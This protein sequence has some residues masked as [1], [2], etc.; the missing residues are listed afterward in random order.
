MSALLVAD[1]RGDQ[2]LK[3]LFKPAASVA[4]IILAF[5][6]GAL[7]TD[8]GRWILVGLVLCLAGDVFLIARGPIVFLAG[9][10]A[11][12]LGHLAYIGAFAVIGSPPS[13]M[14]GITLLAVSAPVLLILRWLW[15]HLGAFRYPVAVY[16]LIISLMAVTSFGTRS[17]DGDGPYWLAVA[18]AV[19]FAISDISVARD[20]FVRREFFNR[21]WGLPLYYAAQLLLAASVSL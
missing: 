14:T 17:P 5:H 1:H 13:L 7:G 18:G 12:A 15:P 19:S 20:Q 11:F 21:L 16:C 6:D 10:S 3:W 4:F 8:Y 2:Q 9:M